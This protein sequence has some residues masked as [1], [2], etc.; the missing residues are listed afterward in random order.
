MHMLLIFHR[1]LVPGRKEEPG[2]SPI[3]S[4]WLLGEKATNGLGRRGPRGSP[5]FFFFLFPFSLLHV[6]RTPHV[7][8]MF[9]RPQVLDTAR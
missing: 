1:V 9:T 2:N 4:G 6:S 7:Y 8:P 3:I 5:P